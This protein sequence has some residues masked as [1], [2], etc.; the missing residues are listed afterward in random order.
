M[1]PM[2]ST[3]QSQFLQSLPP[4]SPALW[5][6][7]AWLIN[8]PDI[9]RQKQVQLSHLSD[10]AARNQVFEFWQQ[11]QLGFARCMRQDPQG[12]AL[13]DFVAQS[14]VRRLGLYGES[15]FAYFFRQQ[16]NLL[17]HGLQ[18]RRAKTTLGEFDFLLQAAGLGMHMELACKYYLCVPPDDRE[19]SL[20]D[21]LG[22]NLA[23]SLGAKL[24][25]ITDQQLRLGD[26]PEGQAV[27]QELAQR[28]ALSGWMAFSH[29]KGCL[30]YPYA[31]ALNSLPPE[32]ADDHARGWI[33]E[34]PELDDMQFDAAVCLERMAWLAPRHWCA[35]QISSPSELR[36][37]LLHIWQIQAT[38][39]MVALLKSDGA[40][41]R[42]VMR[43]FVIPPGW[44][45]R[46]YA[47]S[48]AQRYKPVRH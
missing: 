17:A 18:V 36:Q 31:Q 35:G 41:W 6:D 38:P 12:L 25:K 24:R 40:H 7:L 28:H 34:L 33:L 42:E 13:S 29:I 30:F 10:T 15:L 3:W 1:R 26:E 44:W 5:R 16:E 37:E 48:F 9:L 2:Q 21:F 39:Q 32:L 14:G 46:A 19:L 20:Y 43:V 11:Q 22:P 45:Q 8:S 4:D 47:L 27:L 23:D